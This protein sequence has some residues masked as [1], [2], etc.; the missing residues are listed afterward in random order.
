MKPEELLPFDTQYFEKLKKQGTQLPIQDVFTQIYDTNHWGGND[1]ASGLGS[2]SAQT[3][4][5]GQLLPQLLQKLN[6]HTLLDAPCG[7]FNWLSRLNLPMQNYIGADI[8]PLIIERNRS[9]YT[10][11]NQSFMVLDITQDPLPEADLILCRDCLVH[12]S[13]ADIHKFLLNLKQSKIT[14]L[15]STTFAQRTE[16]QDIVTGDW[17]TL[18]L[19]LAPFNFPA[20]LALLNENCTE[21]NGAYADKCLGL[22]KV[23]DLRSEK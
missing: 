10:A 3:Q 21:A 6:I 1:S 5:L 15:L 23:E 9:V 22:W 14:Y 8:V 19:T 7:D 13:F 17:R 4:A 18:N 2:E 11:D 16:N 12:W 20:P